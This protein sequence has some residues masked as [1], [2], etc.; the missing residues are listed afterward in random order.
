MFVVIARKGHVPY[1]EK[2]R[3]DNINNYLYS[4]LIYNTGYVEHQ[5]G[6]LLHD[7]GQING[8]F[9]ASA[10]LLAF[11]IPAGST[12]CHAILGGSRSSRG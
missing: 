11:Q 4:F 9:Q 8:W 10:L 6:I 1:I 12:P 2:N 5:R 3:T 7:D